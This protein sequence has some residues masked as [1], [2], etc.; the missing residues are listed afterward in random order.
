MNILNKIWKFINSRIFGY[1]LV[2]GLIIFTLH[3]CNQKENVEQ[4]QEKAE[5]NIEALNDTIET[6]ENKLGEKEESIKAFISKVNNLRELNA[7]LYTKIKNTQGTVTSLNHL[8]ASLKQDTSQLRGGLNDLKSK[9]G[10]ITKVNDTIYEIPWTLH[11][12]HDSLNYDRFKGH[13]LF[14]IQN[15]DPLKFDHLNTE[16]I[17]R[18][19]QIELTWG[20]KIVNDRLK[21]FVQSSYPGFSSESLRGVFIDPQENEIFK[22]YCPDTKNKRWFRGFSISAGITT[23]YDMKDEEIGFVVGPSIGIDIY[24]WNW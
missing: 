8:I 7:E 16:I 22:K 15:K 1:V 3:L 2:G 20:Q 4:E 6:K 23:Y 11:Y 12:T 21:V 17:K 9:L 14:T 5:Q 24:S 13:S 18:E 19:T 10:E